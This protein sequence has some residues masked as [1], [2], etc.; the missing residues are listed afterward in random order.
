MA[1]SHIAELMFGW[2]G[3]CHSGWRDNRK[4]S[5]DLQSELLTERWLALC[6]LHFFVFFFCF[7]FSVAMA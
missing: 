6:E 1:Q 4:G 5:S 3:P 2:F 7:F